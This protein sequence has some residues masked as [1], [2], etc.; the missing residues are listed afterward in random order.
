MELR[1]FAAAPLSQILALFAAVYG[2]IIGLLVWVVKRSFGSQ[3]DTAVA[4]VKIGDTM[5]TISAS[6]TNH[7]SDDV[8]TFGEFKAAFATMVKLLEIIEQRSR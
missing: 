4:L 7:M 1:D 6:L 2:P 8:R 5:Q 3:R